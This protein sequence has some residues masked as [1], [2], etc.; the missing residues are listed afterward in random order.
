[1][2]RNAKCV[3]NVEKEGG[4]VR[5]VVVI[6]AVVVIVVVVVYVCQCNV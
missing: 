3:S 5:S 1:M 4:K 6:V 2:R